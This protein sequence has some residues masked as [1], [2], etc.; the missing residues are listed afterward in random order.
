MYKYQINITLN[1]NDT[2]LHRSVIDQNR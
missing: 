2:N 1:E